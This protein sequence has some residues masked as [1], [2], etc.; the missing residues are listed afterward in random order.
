MWIAKWAKATIVD[1]GHRARQD[2]AGQLGVRNRNPGQYLGPRRKVGGTLCAE[3]CQTMSPRAQ[4][5]IEQRCADSL[6]S[7]HVA[8]LERFAGLQRS[9]ARCV[10]Y[11]RRRIC[12]AW[13]DPCVHWDALCALGRILRI[14]RMGHAACILAHS[15]AQLTNGRSWPNHT[16]ND[17]R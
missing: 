16:L 6:L 11:C 1:C 17:A 5:A 4:G 7:P 10:D 12:Y 15:A 14:V 3:R 13:L 2:L 9:F 8:R